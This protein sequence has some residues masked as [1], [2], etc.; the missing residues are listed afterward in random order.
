MHHKFMLPVIHAANP[1]HDA[2]PTGFMGKA[3]GYITRVYQKIALVFATLFVAGTAWAAPV[4]NADII[5]LLDAGMEESVILDVINS[6]DRKFDTSANALVKLKEKG[7]SPTVL[8]A[9]LTPPVKAGAKSAEAS[10]PS[11]APTTASASRTASQPAASK[12]GKLNP[13]EILLVMDGKESPMQY[14]VPNIR[15][16]AR[17]LGFGGVASYAVLAGEKAQLRL[18]SKEIAFIVSV[19]KNAQ[20]VSYLTLANFAVRKNGNREVIT[21]GG[22]MSYSTGIHKDRVVPVTTERL[23]NQ[24]RA[25]DGYIL[26][27]VKPQQ[28]MGFGEYALVLYTGDV[29]VAG[30]FQSATSSFFDFGIE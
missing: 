30:Y 21:G 25:T 23:E 24:S 5:K 11:P 18:P 14:I 3:A 16:A 19:P 10:A 8:K 4:T 1:Q 6:G 13:E 2:C 22:Y 27:Q 15:T 20:P 7:A 28:I 17:A 29:K 9:I 26:Y 12:S